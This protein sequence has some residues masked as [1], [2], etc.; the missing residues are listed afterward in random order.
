MGERAAR[1]PEGAA[2][3]RRLQDRAAPSRPPGALTQGRTEITIVQDWS[4]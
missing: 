1:I 2:R 4:H 3:G